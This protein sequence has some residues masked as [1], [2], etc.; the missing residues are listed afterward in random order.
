MS[1][2]SPSVGPDGTSTISRRRVRRASAESRSAIFSHSGLRAAFRLLPDKQKA[3]VTGGFQCAPDSDECLQTAG[4]CLA[5]CLITR[6]FEAAQAPSALARTP[7]GP[8]TGELGVRV[9]VELADE[10][11]AVLVAEVQGDVARVES[12][13]VPRIPT[14]VVASR[15]VE[16][17]ASESGGAA[18]TI[19]VVRARRRRVCGLELLRDLLRIT[20]DRRASSPVPSSA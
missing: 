18:D 13:D 2:G 14:E 7:C 4:V 3:P 16:V 9:P 17:N 10:L 11:A 19:P 12:E 15:G 8:L 6:S 1:S 5:A 20:A